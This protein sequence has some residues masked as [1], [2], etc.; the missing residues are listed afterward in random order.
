[1]CAVRRF[2][3]TLLLLLVVAVML[4]AALRPV[5]VEIP[6]AELKKMRPSFEDREDERDLYFLKVYQSRD[7]IPYQCKTW[8]SRQL[9]M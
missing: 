9:L 2:L 4:A 6:L 8:I 3:T 7:G 5:C 1:M